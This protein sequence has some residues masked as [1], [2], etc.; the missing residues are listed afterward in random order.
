[1]LPMRQWRLRPQAPQERGSNYSQAKLDQ[2][3]TEECMNYKRGACKFGDSCHR[4][5]V[6]ASP[7]MSA[8]EC[9]A[10]SEE[11]MCYMFKAN[12]TCTFGDK[13]RFSRETAAAGAHSCILHET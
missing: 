1:M 4:K 9:R 3:A 13:C 6:P 7:A 10:A 12:G 5:H 11:G 2:L 8:A